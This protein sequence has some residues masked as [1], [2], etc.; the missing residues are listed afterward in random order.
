M[1]GTV[2]VVIAILAV[3]IAFVIVGLRLIVRLDYN[4]PLFTLPSISGRSIA[5][6]EPNRQHDVHGIDEHYEFL[7]HQGYQ[8]GETIGKGAYAVVKRAYS[9]KLKK[10]VAVK[11]VR[12]ATT[13]FA[14]KFLWREVEVLKRVDHKNVIRVYEVIDS[15]QHLY[16]VMELAPNG[17]LLQELQKRPY[18]HEPDARKIFKK[19][20]K[21]MLHCHRK[22]K[23]FV[24]FALF[25]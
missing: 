2:L 14:N 6:F 15:E 19:I 5:K 16:I 11:I 23:G 22:G 8:L 13:E 24:L 12:R 25:A 1:F 17:D 9:L 10:T 20:L 18:F 21:G 7:R 3:V 4:Y